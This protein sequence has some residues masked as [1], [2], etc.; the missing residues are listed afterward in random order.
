MNLRDLACSKNEKVQHRLPPTPT[1]VVGILAFSAGCAW[2]ALNSAGW[3]LAQQYFAVFD[4]QSLLAMVL[5]YYLVEGLAIGIAVIGA[6]LIYKG[7]LSNRSASDPDSIRAILAEALG[8]HNDFEIG[9]TAAVLYGLVYLLISSVV[10]WQ[11][12]VDFGATYGVTSPSWNAAACCGSPGTVPALIVYLLPQAH[13]ALQILPLDA[14]FAV[15]VPIL[16]GLNVTLAA[17]SLRNR[18]L[19]TNSGWLGSVG[20]L[21]GLFTGCP[22]CAGLF[23]A[24]AAGGLGATTLAVALAPYQIL[25][26][27]LSIPVLLASPF[28]MAASARK[29]VRAACSIP[30]ATEVR[31]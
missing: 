3:Y 13:L 10:V 9:I 2:V 20:I 11:P 14:L 30:T 8:S 26:V 29:A 15:V 24:G 22:T 23:L 31:N 16:V 21:A 17:H 4:Q 18:V 6:Y 7:L 5:R 28:V 25:F 27:V 19:R 12:G 1:L